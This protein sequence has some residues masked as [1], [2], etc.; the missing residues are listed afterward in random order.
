M[1]STLARPVE[2]VPQNIADEI[3]DW[4]SDGKT[5]RAYCRQ[6]QKPSFGTVYAWQKKDPEFAERIAR[7]RE[8][9]QDAIAD[10]CLEIIDTAEDANLGKARVWTRLQL[11]AKWNPKKYGDKVDMNLGGQANNPIQAA[12][13]VEFVNSKPNVSN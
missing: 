6:D 11:L 2:P 13:T 7:A 10:D 1:S 3:V 5:L 9:G 8:S 4:L 12:I